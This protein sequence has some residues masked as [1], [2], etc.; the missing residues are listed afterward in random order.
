MIT[1]AIAEGTVAVG[2]WKLA[3]TAYR[4]GG[5]RVEAATQHASNF[6]SGK[7]VIRGVVRRAL[8]VRVP[9][10]FCKVTLDWTP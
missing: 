10:G 3:A 8:A 1:P 6:T 7:V 9:L 2:S 5:V 4:K